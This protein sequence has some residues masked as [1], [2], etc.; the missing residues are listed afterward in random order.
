MTDF[1][2][3]N[4]RTFSVKDSGDTAVTIPFTP[5]LSQSARS[6][7]C[8]FATSDDDITTISGKDL[9]IQ[10]ADDDFVISFAYTK[11]IPLFGP[12]S[13]SIDYA[14]NSKSL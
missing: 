8:F 9:E 3:A 11:K 2:P 10:K 5:R 7:C 13:L 4:V 14:A 12:V 6:S 1:A